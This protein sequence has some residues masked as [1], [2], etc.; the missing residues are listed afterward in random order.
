[1]EA[2]LPPNILAALHPKGRSKERRKETGSV[3]FITLQRE[4]E[5]GSLP[6]YGFVRESKSPLLSLSH[7]SEAS[8][9]IRTCLSR[10][11]LG[12][13]SEEVVH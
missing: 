9:G 7:G 2:R 1:M 13:E 6:L 4:E 10:V 5:A 11:C 3:D 8:K 12:E